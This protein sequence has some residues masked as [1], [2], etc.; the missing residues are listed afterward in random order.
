MTSTPHVAVGFIGLG[1]QGLPMAIAIAEAGFPLHAWARRPTSLEALAGVPHLSHDDLAGLATESDVVC[2]CVSTDDD[3]MGLLTGGLLANMRPGSIVVN[4]GTGT[5]GQARLMAETC[6]AAAVEFLD[7][8]V[9]GGHAGAVS[10]TLTTMIGGPEAAARTCEPIFRSFSGHVARLGGHGTGELAKLLNNT[11][12][13][14]NHANI[15]D[16]LELATQLKADPVALAEVI[17]TGSGSSAA[18]EILPTGTTGLPAEVVDHAKD[19]LLRDMEL[20]DAAMHEYGTDTISARA[21]SQRAISGANRV[22]N[23]LNILNP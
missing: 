1:D 10:R 12:M 14:M 15:A 18:L 3:V 20:F 17:K 6:A 21:I 7:A 5:P 11:L 22:P 8:P 23:S 9:S 4:H 2:L 16:I 19:V 13:M